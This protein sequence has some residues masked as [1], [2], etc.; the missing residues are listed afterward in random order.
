ME[1][2]T[3]GSESFE[4]TLIQNCEQVAKVEG[5]QEA[6]AVG[7]GRQSV[8]GARGRLW[9][10]AAEKAVKKAAWGCCKAVARRWPP[11]R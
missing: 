1:E 8:L 10:E 4:A 9:P 2:R 7:F 11:S 3:C 6:L 5:S